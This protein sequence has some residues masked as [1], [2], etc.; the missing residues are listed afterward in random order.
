M[1]ITM[2]VIT[3]CWPTKRPLHFCQTSRLLIYANVTHTVG[4][5]PSIVYINVFDT[6]CFEILLTISP[7]SP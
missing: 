7:N 6:Q 5:Q 4:K 2:S 3:N 1:V